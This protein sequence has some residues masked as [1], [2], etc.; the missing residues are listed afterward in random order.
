MGIT[1]AALLALYL[2]LTLTASTRK[3]LSFDEGEQ[4]AIGYNIWLRRDFR[5]EGANGDLVKRWAALPLL[6]SRPAFPGTDSP[7]WRNG[8]PYVL[9]FRFFFQSGN[10]PEALLLQGRIMMALLGI[11]TGL[12]VFLCSREIFGDIGGLVSLGLFTFSPHMLAFGANISTMMSVSLT[13]LGSTWCIWRLLHR[14]TWGWLLGSLVFFG[15]LLLSKLTA[16]VILPVTAVLLAVKLLSGRPLAWD[17]GAHRIFASRAAQIGIFAGLIAFH[18]L[19]GWGSIWAGY[20]FR[21]AASPDPADPGIAFRRQPHRLPADPSLLAFL[22]WSHRMHVLPEGYL[23]GVEWLLTAEDD[24]REAFMNG[25][26]TVGGWRLFFPYSMW[27]KTTPVLPSLLVMGLGGWWWCRWRRETQRRAIPDGP[28]ADTVPSFYGAIPFVTLILVYF[29][30]AVLQDLN[31][32]HRHI[33]PIYPALYILAGAVGFLW[34]CRA[35]WGRA[36]VLLLLWWLPFDA[37]AIYPHYLAYFN[38]LAGGPAQGY[39]HLVDSSLDW[40]MDL[41]GLKRWLVKHNPGDRTPVFLAYFGT[42]SPDYHQIECHRLPGFFFNWRERE[43]YPLTPG[44]Y[45]ISAT[46]LQSVYTRTFGPW[47]RVYERIYQHS[48]QNI[49]LLDRTAADPQQRAALLGKY[50]PSFWEREYVI[51]ERFRFGRLCAWLRHA[52]PPDDDVGY[53]ILI[54]RLGKAD[55]HAALLGPPAELEDAPILGQEKAS[56]GAQP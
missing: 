3:G 4:L 6:I 38:P 44:I 19:F 49:E 1:A 56:D 14:I 10:R 21:Y 9:G 23:H 11:A 43:A 41:P 22:A 36:V 51:Y 33:L 35:A 30:V 16:L 5:M 29:G 52:R 54:W 39:R 13:L 15:L 55:L 46:L 34:T 2:V 25:R 28:A 26:W 18:A 45:A 8:E 12:L 47:N 7:D 37:L 17:L 20:G 24:D 31:I 53:A 27:V 50:S 40:G 42:D 48:R 32:G